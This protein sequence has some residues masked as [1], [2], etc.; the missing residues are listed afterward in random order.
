MI[1][2]GIVMAFSLVRC[3]YHCSKRFE[4]CEGRP[5]Q[6]WQKQWAD[7]AGLL[8]RTKDSPPRSKEKPGNS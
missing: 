7:V 8:A 4:S 6:A 1:F 3:R 5:R 2:R